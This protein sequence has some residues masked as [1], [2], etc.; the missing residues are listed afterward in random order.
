M[1]SWLKKRR[2]D[3]VRRRPFPAAWAAIIEQNVPYVHLLT[4]DDVREL[5]GH[6]QVFIDEKRFEGCGGAVIT[7]EIRVT[8]AA[9]ACI[10]LLHRETDYYPLLDSIIVYPTAYQA[11]TTHSPDGMVQEDGV[12]VRLGESWNRGTVVLSWQDVKWGAADINDGTN[13][14]LHEFAHQLDD[15]AGASDGAPQLAHRSMYVAWAR[16]LGREYDELSTQV[17][18][19]ARTVRTVRTVIDPYGAESPAEFFA[20]VTEA[21]F[22]TPLQ[23]RHHHPELYE[24]LQLFYRQDPARLRERATGARI[25]RA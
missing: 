17:A 20:V 16:V 15:E 5:H 14:V 23:L 8:I 7:D 2:R 18:A 9:Q 10:L 13:L 1:P 4:D 19:R 3:R 22:E 12:D 6:V 11:T 25:G 21:F 24:Q